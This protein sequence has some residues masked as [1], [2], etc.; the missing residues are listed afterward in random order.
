M[1]NFRIKSKHNTTEFVFDMINR[2]ILQCV[3]M[4]SPEVIRRFTKKGD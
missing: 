2:T 3:L 4:S 1:Q